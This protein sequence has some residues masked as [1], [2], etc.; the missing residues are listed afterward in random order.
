M[1][2]LEIFQVLDEV[3]LQY[4]LLIHHFWWRESRLLHQQLVH[5]L[6][7]LKKNFKKN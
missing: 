5:L 4:E 3:L 7:N 1:L 2:L 6:E